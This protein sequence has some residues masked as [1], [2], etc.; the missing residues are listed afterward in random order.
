M[1]NILIYTNTHMQ[2]ISAIQIR[3]KIHEQDPVDIVI[4][5]HSRGA[6]KVSGRLSE[7]GVFRKVYY[8]QT[9]FQEFEQNPFSDL[10]DVVTMGFSLSP[11][12][13]FGITEPDYDEIYFF[14]ASILLYPLIDEIFR[15]NPSVKLV[16][17]EES[18]ASYRSMLTRKG[19][20]RLDAAEKIRKALGK[21]L[22]YDLIHA[23]CC[24]YPKLLE[25]QALKNEGAK[26]F[27]LNGTHQKSEK[28]ILRIPPLKKSDQT[29]MEILNRIYEYDVSKERYRKKYIYF[30]SIDEE[31]LGETELVLQI[32]DIV[33][34]DNLLIKTHPRD[35]RT[36]YEDH[37]LEVIPGSW[38]PWEISQLNY[39]FSEHVFLSLLSNS[40]LN[41]TA[42]LGDEIPTWYLW[43]CVGRS[44][45]WLRGISRDITDVLTGLW[46]QDLCRCIH[47]AENLDDFM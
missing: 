44:N 31:G 1:K 37:G 45:A 3:L 2:I 33:G 42:M 36:V 23:F 14:N 27:Y 30:S 5:D 32:A 20:P 15:N 28:E 41:A 6:E 34:K 8:A 26:I 25:G 13:T 29:F 38:V 22:I 46:K 40:V 43:K 12:N 4:T 11:K 18:L 35:V 9:Y 19:S 47:I 24:Y 39:D 21:P 16:R 17:F 10:G 7:M